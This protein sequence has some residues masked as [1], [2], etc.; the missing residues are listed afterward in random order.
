MVTH[1][2]E[3]VRSGNSW[4]GGGNINGGNSCQGGNQ[5]W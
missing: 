5:G 2:R 1:G 4:K 3:R